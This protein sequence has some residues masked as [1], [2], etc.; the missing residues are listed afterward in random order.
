MSN[1]IETEIVK[2]RETLRRHEYLYYV[3]DRP[4]ISDAGY[5]GLMRRLLEMETAHPEFVSAESPTQRVGGA[6][7]E[8]FVKLRHS[9]PMLRR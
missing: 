9:A 1:A 3:L 8:G 7:R 6:P 2:L 5:D 4:E